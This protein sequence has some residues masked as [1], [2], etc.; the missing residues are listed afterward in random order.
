MANRTFLTPVVTHYVQ[1]FEIN[2]FLNFN[3][4]IVSKLIKTISRAH[5][6]FTVMANYVSLLFPCGDFTSKDT[7][8]TA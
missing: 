4:L 1:L 7:S 6:C 8:V 3:K 5:I 2:V